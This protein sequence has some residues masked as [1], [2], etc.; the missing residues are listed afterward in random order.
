MKKEDTS[1][2]PDKSPCALEEFRNRVRQELGQLGP[3]QGIVYDRLKRAERVALEEIARELGLWSGAQPGGGLMAFRE[4]PVA[5]DIRTALKDL[6]PG[7]MER[8]QALEWAPR[9][10]CRGVAEQA[11]YWV[12]PAEAAD[13]VAASALSGSGPLEVFNTK[14][15]PSGSIEEFT[16]GIRK[17]LMQLAPGETVDFPPILSPAQAEAVKSVAK[18]LKYLFETFTGPQGNYVSVGHLAGFKARVCEELVGLRPGG[19]VQYGPGPVEET[20]RGGDCA[21]L[22]FLGPGLPP[23]VRSVVRQ[24]ADEVPGYFEASESNEDGAAVIAVAMRA[25]P[26]ADDAGDIETSNLSVSG[27]LTEDDTKEKVSRIFGVYATGTSLRTPIL[28][29][30]DLGKFMKDVE[31]LNLRA[32]RSRKMEVTF[33]NVETIFDDVLELQV[34][35]GSRIHHGL[36]LEFFQVFLSKASQLYGWTLVNLL[37]SLLSVFDQPG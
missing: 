15:P 30:T 22:S 32:K 24:A 19:S 36:T 29:K 11:G 4:G 10:F 33:E 16:S 26:E 2:S 9:R 20:A 21:M 5:A 34:D 14:L 3:D 13:C 1:K 28:R 25:L 23:L 12:S 7:E 37:T 35:M 18:E 6:G 17:V 8:F 27:T 31:A